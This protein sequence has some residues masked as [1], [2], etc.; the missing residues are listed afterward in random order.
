MPQVGDLA[1]ATKAVHADPNVL[2]PRVL[3][4]RIVQFGDAIGP[5]SPAV[6]VLL[7]GRVDVRDGY[8]TTSP[9]W[10]QQSRVFLRRVACFVFCEGLPNVCASC[11]MLHSTVR[12]SSDFCEPG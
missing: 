4:D 1:T 7:L 6:L 3:A 12:I 11:D 2:A 9:S 5:L 10:V 8:Q